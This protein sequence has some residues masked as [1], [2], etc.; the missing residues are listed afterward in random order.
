MGAYVLGK[1]GFCPKESLGWG[2]TL[3]CG[4]VT[5]LPLLWIDLLLWRLQSPH[6]P[7]ISFTF[8]KSEH[9]RGKKEVILP[10][11]TGHCWKDR[12][13][14][15]GPSG[16]RI[17]SLVEGDFRSFLFVF[18]RLCIIMTFFPS[19]MCCCFSPPLFQHSP[20][21]LFPTPDSQLSTFMWQ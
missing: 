13:N 1:R 6:F 11:H 20:S 18:R 5:L 2:F 19:K 3:K 15:E 7:L 16:S 17:L 8:L 12:L 4:H 9:C 21:S 14:H 10:L